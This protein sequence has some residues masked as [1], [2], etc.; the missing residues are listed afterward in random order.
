MATL[1]SIL[2]W[3]M[4]CT[5]EPEGPQSTGSRVIRTHPFPRQEAHLRCCAAL[6]TSI[7]SR[8]FCE[9]ETL[10]PLNTAALCCTLHQPW[11][12][13]L[14]SDCERDEKFHMM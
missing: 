6:A 10:P 8:T 5:E 4:A 12:S 9:T 2:V 3:R 1:S 11:P 14:L 13:V 7:D